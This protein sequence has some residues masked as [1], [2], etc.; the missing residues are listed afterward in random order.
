MGYY[1]E[2][3]NY[4]TTFQS[5]L[6]RRAQRNDFSH[7][8]RGYY[9]GVSG[10][11]PSNTVTLPCHHIRI[12]DFLILEGRPCQTTHI[13]I[14]ST[15]GKYR[16]AGLDL[17]TRDRH[18]ETSFTSS[19]AP[20]VTCEAI[21]GPTFSQYHVVGIQEGH[22]TAKTESGDIKE[23]VKILERSNLYGRLA[24][25]LE[26]RNG[27]VRVLVLSDEGRDLAVDLKVIHDSKPVKD[28][29]G[30]AE[31]QYEVFQAAIRAND[32]FEV[33]KALQKG[34]D[35]NT[36]DGEGKTALFHAIEYQ[37]QNMI[38][39][40]L[41]KGIDISVSDKSG[42]TVL[43]FAVS[44]PKLYEI[45]FSLLRRGAL[46]FSGS[47]NGANA[48][49][50]AAA[51]GNIDKVIKLLKSGVKPNACDR[52]GYTALH[53]AARF[54]HYEMALTLIQHGADVN[55]KITH[56]GT[57]V[58]QAVV[59]RSREHHEYFEK[60]RA[61]LPNLRG[62]HLK[63]VALLLQY[64]ASTKYRRS[65]DNLSLGELV[66]QELTTE[67]PEVEESRRTTERRYLQ[68]ILVILNKPPPRKE[69]VTMAGRREPHYDGDLATDPLS[70]FQLR[71][72][73]HTSSRESDQKLSPVRDFFGRGI[74]QSGGTQQI[75]ELELWAKKCEKNS[76][77]PINFWR[78]VHLPVN[79]RLWAE[80]RGPVLVN[81]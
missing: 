31:W 74:G 14:S 68:M 9:S 23:G 58:I 65:C 60:D 78:W 10:V 7:N 59:Q 5:S 70:S 4:Y 8:T 35:I 26:T 77:E 22:I 63:V 6:S 18:A 53:E 69:S 34:S 71:I 33:D 11:V 3:G 48:L 20:S 80:V 47:D 54:G 13:S 15:T 41:D 67:Y 29:T 61:I 28:T 79:N 2:D 45:T 51:V 24:S 32:I 75:Q 52:L 81:Y 42:N 1:D 76:S 44:E 55:A 57:S 49:L 62:G 25:A 73:Y 66:S 27:S 37:D 72:S 50:S 46:S 43:D 56:G 36:V 16:F 19:P 40:L 12:G 38:D 30:D 17:F 21:L 39:H 64:E